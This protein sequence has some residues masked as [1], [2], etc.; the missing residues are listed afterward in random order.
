MRLLAAV[1]LALALS[2]IAVPAATSAGT[3]QALAPTKR[4]APA[5]DACGPRPKK[6]LWGYWSCTFHDDFD[7]TTLDRT[8]WVPQTKFITVSG[9]LHACY[10][11]DPANVR[12][13]NG[14]LDLSLVKLDAPAECAVNA[15]PT[16]YMAG[17][18]STWHLFSQRYGRF[19]A[20]IKVTPSDAAGL[21][22]AFW[23]WPDD[24]YAAINW[25]DSGEIDV[26]ESFS[27]YPSIVGSY[28]HYSADRYGVLYGVN[29]ANCVAKRGEW[30]TFTL[31][32]D[33]STIETFVNG[34]PCLVNAANDPAFDKRFI[35]NL[36]QA[37]GGA[38]WNQF[39]GD[40]PVPA[41]MQ[42]DYVRVWR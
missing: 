3:A 13:E 15:P 20:R 33:P 42:V 22:E 7:G 11:D 37:I 27:A 1:V 26:A 39:T 18:V 9:D 38:S 29:A 10:R 6:T 19:E 16:Q 4:W 23:L 5:D 32:W 28:L 17:S 40:T 36:T 12:V 30:N 41:T 2:T 34:T 35:I 24:R 31:E 8:K 21:H 25:P 14:V